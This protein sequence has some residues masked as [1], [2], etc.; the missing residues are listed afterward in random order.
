MKINLTS[1]LFNVV[2][3]IVATFIAKT[4][5]V[6]IVQAVVLALLMLKVKESLQ[7]TRKIFAIV[8]LVLFI[9]IT[10]FMRGSGEIIFK[11]GPFFFIKQGLYRGI[12]FSLFLI[13]L[14]L[15]SNVL[16][17][18]YGEMG[19]VLSVKSLTRFNGINN[20]FVMVF[21][22]IQIFK[23]SYKNLNTFFNFKSSRPVDRTHFKERII[24]Y[25]YESHD[26]L[27]RYYNRLSICNNEESKAS[28]S[29]QDM[30]YIL[31]IVTL[32]AGVFFYSQK[33]SV[34]L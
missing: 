30:F 19:L 20:F 12:Y 3:F 24:R 29:I 23:V 11:I 16:T 6:V 5:L 21:Y 15:F 32:Y 7:I 4:F 17:A 34:A 28:F 22:V 1:H 25:F 14:F 10:N 18:K 33:L 9:I 27:R 8:P 31:F 13:E 26:E 2:I